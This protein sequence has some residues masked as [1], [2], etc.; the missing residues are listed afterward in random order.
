MERFEMVEKCSSKHIIAYFDI[1]G[2]KDILGR[3]LIAESELIMYIDEIVQTVFRLTKK[4]LIGRQKLKVF[5]F[6]DNFAFCLKI[7]MEK[8]II[9]LLE[10]FVLI[11]QKLQSKL[12]AEF[13]LFIR[14][15]IVQGNIYAN[16]NFIFGEGL[17][18][19]YDIE[20]EIA[21]YPRVVVEHSLVREVV[22]YVRSYSE[23][24]HELPT[25]G[26]NERNYNYLFRE[27][28]YR[29]T[30]KA[31]DR[32]ADEYDVKTICIRKDDDNE[33][34]VDFLYE[35]RTVMD[36][37]ALVKKKNIE[38]SD[39]IDVWPEYYLTL[40]GIC[41]TIIDALI[42]N[43]NNKSVL[44]KYLWNCSYINL[45]CSEN[46]IEPPFTFESIQE[47]AGINL[48]NAK[49]KDLAPHLKIPPKE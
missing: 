27:I 23:Y 29:D 4:P 12:L 41:K 31:N 44:T 16:K 19:A 17:I 40:W 7:P 1:L 28:L 3:G 11:M 36:A 18:K 30:D 39:D 22:N 6:S 2:Y 24:R 5:C 46:G 35:L 26:I 48:K 45:F 33:Y 38:S 15:S 21:L 47:Y 9:L 42:D 13:G 8:A 10:S 20:N 32:N 43:S 34:F 25:V 49:Y 37:E 14:G